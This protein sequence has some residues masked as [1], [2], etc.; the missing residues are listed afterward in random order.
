MQPLEAITQNPYIFYP[1]ILWD[2]V[3]RGLALWKSAQKNQKYWFVALLVVNSVGILPLIYLVVE[4]IK[5]R[6]K[7]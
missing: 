6:K 1:L 2:L 7:V 3:L 4:K 5:N